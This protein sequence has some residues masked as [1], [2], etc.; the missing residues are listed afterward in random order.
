MVP[1]G[2]WPIIY[3]N[4]IFYM[5]DSFR[6]SLLSIQPIDLRVL[7]MFAVLSFATF[8]VGAA[9]FRR[10]KGVLVDYE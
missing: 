3:F 4:P 9:F 7:A 10:F 6:M 8:A 5:G 1:G 2:F